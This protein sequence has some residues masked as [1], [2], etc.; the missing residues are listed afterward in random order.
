MPAQSPARSHPLQPPVGGMRTAFGIGGLIAIVLGLAILVF[1]GQSGAATMKIVA[2]MMGAYVLVVGI[3]YLGSAL[4]STG[5]TGW[6]RTGHVL[7]GVLYIVGGGIVLLNIGA[8]AAALTVFLSVTVGVLWLLEGI[9]A[10]TLLGRTQAKAW[11]AVYGVVSA[12]AGLVL[13]LAP[14][15]AA[16]TLW[17]MLG[18]SMLVLGVVQVVRALRST[19]AAA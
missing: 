2:A 3:V 1:P 14:L 8:T 16:V 6:S 18:A 5:V 10:F 12:V 9:V 4:F 17:I 7:L 15:L 11:T 19:R 13:I